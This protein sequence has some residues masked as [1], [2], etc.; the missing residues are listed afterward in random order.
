M[1]IQK[2]NNGAVL[3]FVDVQFSV[4]A[5]S[6]AH[7]RF[8]NAN[9]CISVII[10]D[11]FINACYAVVGVRQQMLGLFNSEAVEVVRE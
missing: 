1:L 4:F 3:V 11:L 7:H 8:E 2:C 9:K 10:S 5:G 6:Y